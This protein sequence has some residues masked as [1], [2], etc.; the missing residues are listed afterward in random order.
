MQEEA[1]A[2]FLFLLVHTFAAGCLGIPVRLYVA[3]CLLSTESLRSPHR[4]RRFFYRYMIFSLYYMISF[5]FS[6][7]FL[8]PL[9]DAYIDPTLPVDWGAA[10]LFLGCVP[11]AALLYAFDYWLTA[12]SDGMKLGARQGG[13]RR[14]RRA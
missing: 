12:R 7:I 13:K 8:K 10:M 4:F 5:M 9:A 3:S 2:P 6:P 11:M 1:S 14:Q